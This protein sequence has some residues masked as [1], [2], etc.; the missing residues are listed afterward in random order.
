[1]IKQIYCVRLW[2][3]CVRVYCKYD[4]RVQ[5]VERKSPMVPTAKQALL[6][7]RRVQNTNETHNEYELLDLWLIRMKIERR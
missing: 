7:L 6:E 5:K 4:R 2:Q 3:E 1:M